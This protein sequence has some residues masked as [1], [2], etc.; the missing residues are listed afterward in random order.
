MIGDRRL[1]PRALT[2]QRAAR[3][4]PRV[5]RVRHGAAG[6]PEPELGRP[7]SRIG[8]VK[9]QAGFRNLEPDQVDAFREHGD[10]RCP[11]GRIHPHFDPWRRR[12]A[13][14]R[15]GHRQERAALERRLAAPRAERAKR[16]NWTVLRTLDSPTAAVSSV[17]RMTP[18]PS[19]SGAGF[20]W[21]PSAMSAVASV[22]AVTA[23][24]E[25]R[26]PSLLSGRT[27]PAGPWLSSARLSSAL[28]GVPAGA[29]FRAHV[30]SPARASPRR[31]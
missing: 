21:A 29:G 14:R 6:A 31:A 28:S 17:C 4:L 23:I 25:P 8:R 9:E 11:G 15:H 19:P 10:L 5:D 2:H 18:L 7:R 20:C 1:K 22:A 3:N 12:P 13:V 30:A 24:F 26:L 16:R 27:R